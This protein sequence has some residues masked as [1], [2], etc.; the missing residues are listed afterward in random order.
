MINLLQEN[1]EME[2]YS[3]SIHIP[4]KNREEC[5]FLPMLSQNY[6]PN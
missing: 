1:I 3:T 6:Y 4:M 5:A 2:S